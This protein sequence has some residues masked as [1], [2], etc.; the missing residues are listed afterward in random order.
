MKITPQQRQAIVKELATRELE[1]R[2][3]LQQNSLYE[4]I[5]YYYTHELKKPF[6][7]NWHVKLIAETLERMYAGEIKRLIVNV[8]PRSGKTDLVTRFFPVWALC[9][10]PRLKFIA[11]GYSTTLTQTFSGQARDYFCAVTTKQIFPRQSALKEDINTKENW[12]TVDGGGYYATGS[13]G[14]LT[15]IG[16]D[17]LLLDD[18]L[19]AED[20][21]SDIV[22][23]GVNN[24]FEHTMVSRLDNLTDGRIIVISQRLH[25]DDLPGYLMQK[26]AEGLGEKWHRI[27]IPAIAEKD[28]AYRKEGESFH[29]E[30][31][32]IEFLRNLQ[33]RDKVNF[34]C[35]YQQTP[36]SKESQEFHEEWFRYYEY[37]PMG[38]R[39]FTACD[40]AFTKNKT[41]DYSAIITGKFIEDKMYVIEYTLARLN[42]AELEDKLIYHIRK[43][44]PEKVGIEAYQA[45]VTIGY[46]L[47]NRLLK[48]GLSTTIE[49]IRQ[50]GDKLSKI[51][52]LIPLYRNGQIYHKAGMSELEEQLIKFPRGTHDDLVDSAQMLYDLYTLQ[53]NTRVMYAAPRVEF[54]EFG[55][56]VII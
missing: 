55:R 14:S 10:N 41:S 2:H 6:F 30:R 34:S 12:A 8:P 49:D 46:S 25:D 37:I 20:A 32:P 40:P 21:D 15:G 19:K 56:P 18:V 43:W 48:E 50:S 13:G 51:R 36:I 47:K 44:Q 45:Q 24:W 23:V 35:Q 29:E 17:Y 27:I 4:F 5:K 39:I 3:K 11:T 33:N 38:G 28:D 26:E 53:P 31:F 54:N 7:E 52:R 16:A 22:R 9:R 1:K 42:P